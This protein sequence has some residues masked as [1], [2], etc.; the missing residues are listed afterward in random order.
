[1]GHLSKMRSSGSS[2]SPGPSSC[3]TSDPWKL[4]HR[5]QK[6]DVQAQLEE[7]MASEV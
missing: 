4:K 3:L 2:H 6:A 5:G 7:N 1:M